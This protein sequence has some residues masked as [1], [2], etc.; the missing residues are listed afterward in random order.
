[1]L[2]SNLNS[3]RLL[4]DKIV[5]VYFTCKIFVYFSTENDQPR[6]PALCQLYRQTFV[7]HQQR[8][9]HAPDNFTVAFHNVT[10]SLLPPPTAQNYSLRNRPHNRQLPD[11]ISRITDC[12]FIVRIVPQYVL[13]F[14]YFRPALC[15]ILAY[16]TTAV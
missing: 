5:P 3:F 15:F 13:T 7:P 9:G 4:F 12:N 14:I 16:S 8:D 10:I 2:I 1:M 11:R 6:D